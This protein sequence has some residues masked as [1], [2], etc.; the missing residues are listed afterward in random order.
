MIGGVMMFWLRRA[1]HCL[2]L[3]LRERLAISVDWPGQVPPPLRQTCSLDSPLCYIT[4]LYW[5]PDTQPLLQQGARGQCPLEQ[6]EI[7]VWR[8]GVVGG[9]YPTIP[10]QP[11]PLSWIINMS[12]PSAGH[13]DLHRHLPLAALSPG[14]QPRPANLQ[15]RHGDLRGEGGGRPDWT[16]DPVLWIVRILCWVC[17]DV[18]GNCLNY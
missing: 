2:I 16:G 18:R 10:A 9:K 4:L 5:P 17:S 1:P 6:G 14:L 12:L 7:V 8:C 11:L 3:I 15:H 13:Q